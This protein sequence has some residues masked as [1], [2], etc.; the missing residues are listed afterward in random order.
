M[1][2]ASRAC[3][4]SIDTGRTLA[5]NAP[6]RALIGALETRRL[7]FELLH[8]SIELVARHGSGSPEHEPRERAADR[9]EL[10]QFRLSLGRQLLPHA[11]ERLA[12][13]VEDAPLPAQ[14]GREREPPRRVA[15]PRR[16]LV[17]RDRDVGP[18]EER[19]HV[20]QLLGLRTRRQHE[21]QVP[22]AVLGRF[23]LQPHRV[24]QAARRGRSRSPGW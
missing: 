14:D 24:V 1:P 6:L 21:P 4:A 20:A 19:F 12:D 7:G 23:R 5:A 15:G 18:L 3:T 11:A 9:G 8:L 2:S 10:V 22:L 13:G 16:S 17:E